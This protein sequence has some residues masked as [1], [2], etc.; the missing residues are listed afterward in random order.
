MSNSLLH[1]FLENVERLRDRPCFTFKQGSKWETLSWREALERVA[2]IAMGLKTLGIKKGD[3][4]VIFSNTSVEWTLLDL[5]ILSLGGVTVP[6]Y[7]SSTALQARFI[8][9]NSD[10]RIVAVEG[11]EHYKKVFPSLSELPLV[12][13]L[14]LIEGKNPGDEKTLTLNQLIEKG[15]R[16]DTE[17]WRR[18]IDQIQGGDVAT[19]VYT[20]GTTGNP[21]GA[22]LTHGNF[23]SEVEA[24]GSI[25]GISERE[26]SIIFLP[27]AHILARVLQFYQLR[28]GYVQAYAESIE[29]LVDNIGEV[30][31]HF[32]VSVPRIFEKVYERVLS[33][34]EAGSPLKKALFS[35]ATAVGKEA[36]RRLQRREKIPLKLVLQREIATWLV[37]RKLRARL[38]GRLKF[39]V[40]G[41]APLS[42]EIAEFFHAAGIL[43]LEGYGL[44]ETTAAVNCNSVT[45][46]RFGT[47]GKTIAGVEEKLADDG[48]ILVRGPV[49]FKGYYKN[50]EGT[51]EALSEE[52]WFK[53]GDIGEIADDGFLR[54]TDRKKDIIVT[55]AG[56]NIAPQNIENLIKTVPI[57]SQVMVYGDRK[58]YLAA[59]VTLNLDELKNY[60]RT[61]QIHFHDYKDLV[62]NP[63]IYAFVKKAIEEKNKTLASYETVKRFTILEDDF[64]QETGELT[65][66]LKVKRKFVSQKYKDVI[67]QLYQE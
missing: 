13:H 35:W 7:Q 3:A 6:I 32:F 50:P 52:G 56:K 18:G 61:R 42:Q 10:A 23:T 43:V 20:S 39:C 48:E 38:G 1:P 11:R 54:I 63:Q 15:R 41:G 62:K 45:D 19:Y 60:A 36:S 29:K 59:L 9:Q 2:A 14:I 47:V 16:G 64:T 66:T 17:A 58:K 44:T 46:F 22:I 55:A 57:I 26:Y 40:S 8:I 51:R 34:V 21:K 65:P 67:E 37:F 25:F 53:T 33:Q 28:V 12:T 30:R 24:L 49:I 4:V 27:L 31:P 5:A